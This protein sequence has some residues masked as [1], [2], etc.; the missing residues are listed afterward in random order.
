[1]TLTTRLTLVFLAALGVVLVAFSAAT[2]AL[3]SAH[4]HRRLGERAAATLD[5]LSAA[6]EVE[7]DGIEWEPGGHRLFR[8]EDR[9]PAWAAFDGT[10]NR[11]GGSGD[12]GLSPAGGGRD[13][14][15]VA[16]RELRHPVPSAVRSND[17]RPRYATLVFVSA[18]PTA[19]VR[20]ALRALATGLAGV[21]VA[22]WLAAGGCARWVC[23]RALAPVTRMTAAATATAADFARLPVP[24][25]R[26][27]LHDLATAF[28]GL[29]GR[30]QDAFERQR[31]FTA[32]A[33]HQLRTPLTAM[34]G[35]MEVALRRDRD[36]A[37]YRRTL[38]TGID[39][40]RRLNRV[41]EMLLFLARA[42]AEARL[43]DLEPTDLAAWLP[44]HVAESWAS[45]PR[46]AGITLDLPAGP[47]VARVEP[48]LLGQAVDNLIDN[49]LKYGPPGSPVA[50][51]LAAG[52]G[53]IVLSV[54]D[55]GPGVTDDDPGRVFEPFFRS[56]NARRAGVAGV[57][58]GLAVAAR[59]V[60]AF[61][62]TITHEA[63]AGGCR[64]AVRLPAQSWVAASSQPGGSA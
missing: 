25:A 47:Q 30:L 7:G 32:E 10:G 60:A 43:P 15:L 41:V 8:G 34:L 22:L 63:A 59:I 9:P 44:T 55:G 57:G 26:D 37:E 24:A 46:Y 42:E 40:A 17:D 38:A 35:Q 36:P 23:R 53:D 48:A 31:R 50:V 5:T 19:P 13:G 64:F 29:L 20:E 61:G 54:E 16:R 51:R 11:V 62:G 12:D 33:S 1:V 27:E 45:N 21:S 18:W 6:A 4:L 39:Q 14:W 58:L 2:L 3:A 49:A 52:S 28:N 56:A